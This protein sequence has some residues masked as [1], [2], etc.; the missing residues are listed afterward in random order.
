MTYREINIPT[1]VEPEAAYEHFDVRFTGALSEVESE[2][3]LGMA[4][5]AAAWCNAFRDIHDG[6]L[7]QRAPIGMLKEFADDAPS[8]FLRGYVLGIMFVRKNPRP[9]EMPMT[10]WAARANGVDDPEIRGMATACAVMAVLAPLEQLAV[11]QEPR[12]WLACCSY[13]PGRCTR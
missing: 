6:D 1:F 10:E 7:A 5:E 11:V 3:A 13:C 9:L 2:L 12:T 8:S 4:K